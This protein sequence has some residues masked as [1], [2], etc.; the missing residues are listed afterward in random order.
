MNKFTII[1]SS[2]E[3][4]SAPSVDQNITISLEE[5][6]QQMVEYDRSASI[7]LAQI[8][9]EE[10]QAS[11]IFRPTFKVSYLYDNDTIVLLEL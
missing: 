11:T 4:K 10:R 3:Y 2:Q 8:Y 6:S 7:S 5:Q 1:P 9:D